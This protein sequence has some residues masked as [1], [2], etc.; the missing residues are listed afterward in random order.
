MDEQ[1]ANSL[2]LD[3]VRLDVGS[4]DKSSAIAADKER[5]CSVH[6]VA[7]WKMVDSCWTLKNI[8]SAGVAEKTDH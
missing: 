6:G 5:P 4:L 8:P 1:A 3:Y 7:G 2:V